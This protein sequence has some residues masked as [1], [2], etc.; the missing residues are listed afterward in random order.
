MAARSIESLTRDG[1][2]AALDKKASDLLVLNLSGISPI[3]DY[4]VICSAASERQTQAIAE[5]IEERM[6]S[7]GRRPLS[8][9]GRGAGRWIL[10][11][12]G[13]VLFHV[14]LEEA[15]RFY[16]LERLWGDAGDETP[17]FASAR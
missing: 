15:R 17:R 13:D 1:V 2:A 8:V 9:E 5:A 14:F 11:D 10:L 12:Y 4:F 3:A 7:A 6:S 16:A